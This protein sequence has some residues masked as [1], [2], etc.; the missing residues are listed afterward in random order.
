MRNCTRR[1]FETHKATHKATT[2]PPIYYLLSAKNICY[3]RKVL[4][5]SKMP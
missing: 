1:D 5:L 4:A 3:L 2:T